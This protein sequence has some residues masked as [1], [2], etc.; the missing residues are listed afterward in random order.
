VRY[1]CAI[2]L[3]LVGCSGDEATYRPPLAITYV[4]VPGYVVKCE[5]TLFWFDFPFG[6]RMT[7]VIS[8]QKHKYQCQ[9]EPMP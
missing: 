5:V 3:L 4:M 6:L 9:L 2:C 7:S 1:L 8:Y